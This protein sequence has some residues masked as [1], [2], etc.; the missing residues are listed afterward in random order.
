[1]MSHIFDAF[2]PDGGCRVETSGETGY[3][4]H[5]R[6][7]PSPWSE[8]TYL[9]LCTHINLLEPPWIGKNK[10][11]ILLLVDFGSFRKISGNAFSSSDERFAICW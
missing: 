10:H 7:F 2:G 4:S 3:V 5:D 11:F 6:H 8:H 9:V 1:M